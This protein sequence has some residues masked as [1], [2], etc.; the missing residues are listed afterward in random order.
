MDETNITSITQSIQNLAEAVASSTT[1]TCVEI[2][3][4]IATVATAIATVFLVFYNCRTVNAALDQIKESK[5]AQQLQKNLALYPLRRDLLNEIDKRNVNAIK[6]MAADIEVLLPESFQKYTVYLEI[7]RTLN[8]AKQ[9]REIVENF[10]RDYWKESGTSEEEMR[11]SMAIALASKGKYDPESYI[12]VF[13]GTCYSI[14]NPYA[15]GGRETYYWD[16]E[17]ARV[18]ELTPKEEAAF[19][20]FRES[21]KQEIQ[22]TLKSH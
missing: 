8:E 22:S 7:N 15:E 3:M 13:E 9:N 6:N 17:N 16:E 1:P 19:R 20:D 12:E 14:E 21:V 11:N 4:L 18:H 10:Y 2:G 5:A